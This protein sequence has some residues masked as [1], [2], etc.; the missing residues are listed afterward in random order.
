M[1]VMMIMDWLWPLALGFALIWG[2]IQYRENR[3]WRQKQPGL[4]VL[5]AQNQQLQQE[6]VR[7]TEQ[8]ATLYPLQGEFK[9]QSQQL[10]KLHQQLDEA[11]QDYRALND[12][13]NQAQSELASVNSRLDAERK[14][15]DEKMALLQSAKETLTQE[16]KVLS[17]EI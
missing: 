5:D 7:L 2:A 8:L 9:Q 4:A 12:Q 11:K 15:A 1:S 14:S 3:Q 6:N 16:F 13:L 17:N 10:E